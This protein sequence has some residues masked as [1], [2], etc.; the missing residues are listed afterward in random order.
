MRMVRG[1]AG[2]LLRVAS[3]IAALWGVSQLFDGRPALGA[4]A[5]V[6]AI[7]LM[8]AGTELR[9]RHARRADL[10][11]ALY[12]AGDDMFGYKSHLDRRHGG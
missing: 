2:L 8:I 11:D 10:T 12:L 6:G 9:S 5:I 7:A 3:V 1:L 4:G